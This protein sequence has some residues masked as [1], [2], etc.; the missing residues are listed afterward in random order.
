M[1]EG[2]GK[3]TTEMGGGGKLKEWIRWF[4]RILVVTR[5]N[6]YINLAEWLMISLPF[7]NPFS[8]RGD[9]L[10]VRIWLFYPH[11]EFVPSLSPVKQLMHVKCD[12][13]VLRVAFKGNKGRERDIQRERGGRKRVSLLSLVVNV[14][15]NTLLYKYISTILLGLCIWKPKVL[16]RRQVMTTK[17]IKVG[18]KKCAHYGALTEEDFPRKRMRRVWKHNR[19]PVLNAP[20][21]FKKGRLGVGRVR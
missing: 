21:L 6:I 11:L 3:N 8:P 13:G 17:L 16:Q 4:T 18:T 7:C 14:S 15:Q 10:V 1:G 20:L 19:S 9:G 12:G 2:D 5:Y